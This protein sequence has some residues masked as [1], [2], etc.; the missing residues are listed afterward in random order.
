MKEFKITYIFRAQLF[1]EVI[2]AKNEYDATKRFRMN[3]AL[4]GM[5]RKHYTILSVERMDNEN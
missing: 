2:T 5:Q 3:M 4:D 1:V